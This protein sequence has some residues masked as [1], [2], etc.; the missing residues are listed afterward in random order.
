MRELAR[1]SADRLVGLFL[2]KVEAGACVPGTGDCCFSWGVR[3]CT[4]E[5]KRRS[6]LLVRGIGRA[7]PSAWPCPRQR[8]EVLDGPC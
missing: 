6:A 1:R 8:G 7:G 5:C 2:P 3:L 4:G